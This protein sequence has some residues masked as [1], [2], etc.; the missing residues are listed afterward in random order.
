MSKEEKQEVSEET[1]ELIKL[2]DALNEA[3]ADAFMCK[4]KAAAAEEKLAKTI[5]E[6]TTLHSVLRGLIS[7]PKMDTAED[8]KIQIRAALTRDIMERGDPGE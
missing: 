2:G 4:N 7:D 1:Q 8:L 3:I 6:R 5:A